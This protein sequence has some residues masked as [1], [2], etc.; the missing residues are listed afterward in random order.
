MV[1]VLICSRARIAIR[2]GQA[3]LGFVIGDEGSDSPTTNAHTCSVSSCDHGRALERYRKKR[4][5]P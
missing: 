1:G 4:M 2:G 3:G 5:A